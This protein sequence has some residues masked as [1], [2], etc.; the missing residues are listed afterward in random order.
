MTNASYLHTR[1]EP[2]NLAVQRVDLCM[3]TQVEAITQ[4]DRNLLQAATM[5]G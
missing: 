4:R 1:A 5:R 2:V 3:V